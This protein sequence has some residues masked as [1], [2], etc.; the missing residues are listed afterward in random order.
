MKQNNSRGRAVGILALLSL[1]LALVLFLNRQFIADQI[2]VW[3]YQPSSEMATFADRTGM[4]SGGKFA[5]YSSKPSLESSQ[6]FNT[7]CDRKEVSTAILGCYNGHAIYIYNVT[8]QQLDGIREVTAAHEMLHAAY[9][10]L[11]DSERDRVNQLV[12]AEYE[13]LKNR[14]DFAERMAFYE[15]TEPGERDNELHSIIG[16]EVK[17]ISV[18]LEAHYKKYFSDRAK[19]VALHGKYVAVFTDLQSRSNELSSQLTT[20]GEQIKSQTQLY[21]NEVSS[22]NGA[23]QSFNARA[24]SGSFSSEAAFNS[25]RSAL[26]ARLDR[27]DTLRTQ[28]NTNVDSYNEIRS[29][30]IT[31]ASESDALNQSIDSTLAPAPSI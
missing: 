23:V 21:N 18:D 15:R 26:A 8:N 4:N 24:N 7:K 19:V 20:L 17:G 11:P 13:S 10:R 3:Q 1:V 16:T 6:D 22:L 28:I 5:F 2:T 31:I 25:E 27:L 29:E 12:E 14:P 30:L 9:D